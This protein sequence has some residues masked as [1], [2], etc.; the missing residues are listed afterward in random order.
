MT[1]IL[2]PNIFVKSIMAIISPF[3]SARSKQKIRLMNKPEELHEF[4]TADNL[5]LEHKGTSPYV[6]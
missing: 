4:W 6:Y 3:L 1:V 2:Y 5:I